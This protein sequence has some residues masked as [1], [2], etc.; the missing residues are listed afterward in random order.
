MK[1]LQI[2][3]HYNQ[4]GAAR[5][6]A[7]IHRQLLEE[8]EESY[9]AYGRGAG[10]EEKNVICI[11]KKYEVYLSALLC[12]I[13]GLNG[14]LNKKAAKRLIALMDEIQPDIVHIHTLHGYYMNFKMLM[15]Y[16]DEHQIPCVWTFHD[17]HAFTGN[18]GYYFACRKWENGCGSCLDKKRYP[19]SQFFDFSRYMW[20][21]KKEWFTKG[22]RKII[23]TP[24]DWLT[25]ET[26][27]SF[28]G[29]Y[30]CVTIRNGIDAE[31][32]FYPRDKAECR[33]K[34]GF[35]MQDKLVLGMA[36][37]F[38][39]ERKGAKFLIGSAKAMENEAKFILVGWEEKN[40]SLLEGI[41]NVITVPNT[42]DTDALAEY[43]SLADVFVIPSLAENY[44]TVTLESMACGTPVVG[45]DA[46]GIPEQ[47]TENKGIVVKTADQGALTEAVR[48]AL[49][50]ESGL[51]CGDELAE[52][53]RRN[54]SIK[55]MTETYKE[56]YR[57]LLREKSEVF[58]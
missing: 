43:Y 24:S 52:K 49:T 11:D 8:G 13:T 5:I 38:S 48:K 35:T 6:V 41:S 19:K 22:D 18:C 15:K 7:C 25:E 51:L 20:K 53:I 23:V 16:L 33:K 45:F 10:D 9:V 57:E 1:I 17:C 56:I 26:K 46:G 2:N 42:K 21:K 3:S 32:T 31:H 30:P 54:N 36:A 34:Y 29:K 50:S 12:R 28:F 37:G 44:A 47:L 4:G 39:D 14:W 27:K 55:Q 40:N 58:I